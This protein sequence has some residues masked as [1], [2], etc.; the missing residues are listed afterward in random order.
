MFLQAAAQLDYVFLKRHPNNVTV[1]FK[2]RK[3]G[4]FEQTDYELLDVLDF[5]SDRKRMSVIVKMPDGKIVLICKGADTVIQER[6]GPRQGFLEVTL[7]HLE[8]F[9]HK[10]LRTL[11]VASV[12]LSPDVYEKWKT[13]HHEAATAMEDRK[14]KVGYQQ[15]DLIMV[16]ISKWRSLSVLLPRRVRH[17]RAILSSLPTGARFQSC[18]LQLCATWGN[19]PVQVVFSQKTW[20]L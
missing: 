19:S 14:Q 8:E 5:D 3:T 6:L 7:A 1:R 13:R 15:M 4:Q 2:N 17:S 18:W 10:G 16:A 11:C 9:A 20:A 12:D